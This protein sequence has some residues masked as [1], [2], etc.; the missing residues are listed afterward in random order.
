MPAPLLKTSRVWLAAVAGYKKP[1]HVF[2][3]D[4]LPPNGAGKVLKAEL[5]E[6][7]RERVGSADLPA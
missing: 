4:A 5:R 2:F 3:V 7:A 1:K 6:L